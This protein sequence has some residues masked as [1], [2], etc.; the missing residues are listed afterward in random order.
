MVGRLC[1]STSIFEPIVESHWR[2]VPTRKGLMMMSGC[3]RAVIPQQ[4]VLSHPSLQ[5]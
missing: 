4:M 2:C 3:I 5:G 1:R